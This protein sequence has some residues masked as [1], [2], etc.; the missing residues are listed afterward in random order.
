MSKKYEELGVSSSKN[1]V[2]QALK[3]IDKGI[4][5]TAFC[6]I[7]EDVLYNDPE[8]CNV[9]HADGAGTKTSLAYIYYKE[10][11][12]LNIFRGVVQDSI[13]MNTDDVACVGII[14][15]LLLSNTIG[16]NKKLITGEILAI[17]I[18]EF[19]QF[20][21]KLR[22]LGINIVLTGGETADVGDIVKTLLI[23]STIIAR[24]KRNNLILNNKITNGDIIIGFSSFGKCT[25]E[26]KYNSG[27]GSNGLTLARHGTLSSKY[28]KKYPESYDSFINQELIYSGNHELFD[29]IPSI[30]LTIG[31]ALLSPTRTYLPILKEI[32]DLY[33]KDISALIHC[34]G[35]GQTKCL[36]SG[37]NIHYVKD[38]LFDLPVIFEI[39][40]ESS[41]TPW[42][43][44]YQVF[45]MGH[46]LELI[47][48]ESISSEIIKISNKFNI[49]AK[50]IGKCIES[51]KNQLTINSEQGKFIYS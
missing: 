47:C 25:Y 12:D 31:E 1:E 20:T 18:D 29:K 44:M 8:Y 22:G 3:N 51:D 4:F 46:R 21:E 14:N 43:E 27:I 32:F 40:Q 50:I 33:R 39:I 37:K 9:M 15:N 41:K 45:N 13:V 6:K 10:S 11:N 30:G 7:N 34:T 16:R 49:E 5:P 2:H 26:S 38:N 24:E 19:N 48:A 36:K 28:K 17:L 23:D 42:K 35:G